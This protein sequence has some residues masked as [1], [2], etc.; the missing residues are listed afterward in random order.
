MIVDGNVGSRSRQAGASIRAFGYHWNGSPSDPGRRACYHCGF[1][2]SHH[3]TDER[4]IGAP[5][6]FEET[7]AHSTRYGAQYV[8]EVYE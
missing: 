3:S 1:A 6:H 4:C 2:Y 5:S 7:R 8:R